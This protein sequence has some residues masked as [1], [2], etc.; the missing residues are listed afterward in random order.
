MGRI[1]PHLFRLSLV[2]IAEL[3]SERVGRSTVSHS[4]EEDLCFDKQ[5]GTV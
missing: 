1:G 3:S 4:T 5:L 2:V